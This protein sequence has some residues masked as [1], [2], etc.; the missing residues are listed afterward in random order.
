M[1][2]INNK[3]FAKTIAKFKLDDDVNIRDV[4]DRGVAHIYGGNIPVQQNEEKIKHAMVN[5]IRHKHS[6]YNMLMGRVRTI[7]NGYQP[8]YNVYR[9]IVLSQIA[10]QYP[11]L[12]DEC[13]KQKRKV[14]MVKYV[15]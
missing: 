10:Q 14:Q 7:C 15:S 6:N 12:A 13:N 11:Y 9:N 1:R 5:N 4:Y 2:S 3:R 8:R